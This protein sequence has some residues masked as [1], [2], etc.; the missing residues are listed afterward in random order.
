MVL[1]IFKTDSSWNIKNVQSNGLREK[2]INEVCF[3][4]PE[5]L[6]VLVRNYRIN[7]SS[8]IILMSGISYFNVFVK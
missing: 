3:K 5:N 6:Y 8:I 1:N 7:T 4:N 2:H